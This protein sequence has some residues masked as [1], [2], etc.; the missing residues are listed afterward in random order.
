MD[1]AVIETGGK[2]YKVEKGTTL[3][4]DNLGKKVDEILSINNVL[5]YVGGD[6]VKIGQPYIDGLAVRA[7]VLAN[8]KSDKIRI[9]KFK[10]KAKYRRS[11]GFR[12]S[13]TRLLIEDIETKRS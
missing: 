10:A 5:L 4:V 1:Y 3:E 13:L 2:Q 11:T 12:A 7:K 6:G 9:V 8:I